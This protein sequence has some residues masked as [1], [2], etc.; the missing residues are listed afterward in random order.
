MEKI[1]QKWKK[2]C[3]EKGG[4]KCTEK[5]DNKIHYDVPHSDSYME[6]VE[7]NAKKLSGS[8]GK[9]RYKKM[10]RKLDSTRKKRL[11]E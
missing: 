6:I 1:Q 10:W 7:K 11:L 3:R 4:R 2:K 9:K 8:W 5:H